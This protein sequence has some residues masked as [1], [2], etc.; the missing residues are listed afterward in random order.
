LLSKD[1]LK[2]EA[3]PVEVKLPEKML[4]R[5]VREANLILLAIT[6]GSVNRVQLTDGSI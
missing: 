2:I 1:Q 6:Q 5:N 3:V 4:K